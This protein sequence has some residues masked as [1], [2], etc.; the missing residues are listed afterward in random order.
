ML[1]W[2]LYGRMVSTDK[3]N[4]KGFFVR[5]GQKQFERLVA[6]EVLGLSE[7]SSSN[8]KFH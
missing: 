1:G 4:D 8:K 7:D 6:L 3:E 5:S 2:I